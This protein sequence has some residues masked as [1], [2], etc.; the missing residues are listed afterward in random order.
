MIGYKGTKN[1]KCLD[2]QYVPGNIYKLVSDN[3]ELCRHGFHFCIN[4][5]NINEYYPI[6]DKNTIIFEIEAIG[7]II[8]YGNKRAT[9]KIRIIQ[10]IPRDKYHKFNTDE[11]K[12]NDKG[13]LIYLKDSIG[14]YGEYEYDENN[15]KINYKHS[16]G[17]WI[18]Y[19][20]DSNSNLI[21]S[22]NCDRFWLKC[23]YDKHN[24]LI[25][26]ED[27]DRF[28]SKHKYD[29]NNNLI[30]SE[31]SYG[32]WKKIEYDIN[33][34]EIYFEDS[35]GNLKETKYDYDDNNNLIS[36]N[37]NKEKIVITKG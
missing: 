6:H 5:T 13:N 15:N 14:D 26:F 36:V 37:K 31:N 17:Y 32:Y 16:N 20:Y 11:I 18:K 28:W 25:Y 7:K 27:S 30:Y 33:N 29:K 23:E 34:N 24:N 12:F 3:L 9:N 35:N 22:E 21:Y 8:G 1:G 2:L 4:F 19:R 10:E